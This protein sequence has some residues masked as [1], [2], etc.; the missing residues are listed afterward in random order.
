MSGAIQI[1]PGCGASVDADSKFCG[2][3][4]SHLTG[5]LATQTK[6][7]GRSLAFGARTVLGMP[8]APQVPPPP[9]TAP[10][11]PS[12]PKSE[13][14]ATDG[15][16]T[17]SS[18]RNAEQETKGD[19]TLAGFPI[20]ALP[21][22]GD[23]TAST[24]GPISDLPNHASPLTHAPFEPEVSW[25]AKPADGD[26]PEL[27]EGQP[28]HHSQAKA[29]AFIKGLKLVF[30]LALVCLALFASWQW[31]QRHRLGLE[32][33]IE[34]SD[35]GQALRVKPLRFVRGSRVRFGN[36]ERMLSA[37][38][39]FFRRRRLAECGRKQGV[40]DR[41]W[42]TRH[43]KRVSGFRRGAFPSAFG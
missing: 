9:K 14:G 16:S 2:S 12:K 27:T 29:F 42:P 30:A 26:F 6:A 4:G 24:Q 25:G 40:V 19:H 10:A 37:Q 1:C 22:T 23:A 28:P 5:R 43:K 21:V 11:E 38:G 36:V 31:W 18:D 35:V 33:V 20:P 3:C 32:V 39:A 34:Q 13:K 8:A 17:P 41:H 7:S 15:K